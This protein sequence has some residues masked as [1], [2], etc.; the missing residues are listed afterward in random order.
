MERVSSALT[1]VYTSGNELPSP[2][3]GG[4]AV[5]LGGVSVCKMPQIYV[6]LFSTNFRHFRQ[7]LVA[8]AE[9]AAAV[10][11][12][13]KVFCDGENG[14]RMGFLPITWSWLN[15]GKVEAEL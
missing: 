11:A 7:Y 6:G 13:W 5:E 3:L 14:D 8:H 15:D 1:L 10:P 12:R 2:W 4:V 9:A